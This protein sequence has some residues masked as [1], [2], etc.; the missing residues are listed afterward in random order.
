MQ[1]KTVNIVWCVCGG[2]SFLVNCE[3]TGFTCPRL[4]YHWTRRLTKHGKPQKNTDTRKPPRAHAHPDTSQFRFCCTSPKQYL[5]PSGCCLRPS[6]CR[7][8]PHAQHAHHAHARRTSG[9]KTE[10]NTTEVNTARVAPLVGGAPPPGGAAAALAVR[11]PG[12]RRKTA[13]FRHGKQISLQ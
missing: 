5:S 1:N 8:P 3:V 2:F 11:P 6:V 13:V 12:K 7:V 4:K 10:V 9:G